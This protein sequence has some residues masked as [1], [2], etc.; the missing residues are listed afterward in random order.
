MKIVI[1]ALERIQGVEIYPIISLLIFFAF[2]VIMSYLVFNLDKGYIDKMKNMPLEEDDDQ[3]DS[4]D[5][6]NIQN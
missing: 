6:N 4:S 5:F 1:D 2:F 3:N